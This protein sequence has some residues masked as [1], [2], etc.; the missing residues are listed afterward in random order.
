MAQDSHTI[1]PIALQVQGASRDMSQAP[2]PQGVS[3]ASEA[4]GQAHGSSESLW[5]K[6]FGT[7]ES[8]VLVV[9][10]VLCIG[11]W[12]VADVRQTFYSQRNWLNLSRQVALLS[13]FAIGETIVILTGGIDLSLGSLI[14]FSGMFLAFSVTRL[15]SR[16]Y[17]SMAVALG[18][19]VALAA[20]FS[21]GALHANLIHK[22]RLP[23]FV[24]TLASLSILRSQ[25]LLMNSQLP[26]TLNDYP[27]L[28][29]LANGSAFEKS[30]FQIP[31]PVVLLVLVAIVTHML[32]SR[33]RIGR[34]V[35]SVGSNEIGTKLSGVNV[36]R[37][38]LFAYG[39]S[40]LLGGVAGILYAGYSTQG[41][42]QNGV[43]YELNAVAAA[44]IGGTALTGGQGTVLG[45]VL[46]AVLLN[47]ILT[48]LNILNVPNQSL[49]QGTV[50]GGVLLLAVLTTAF[51][52]RKLQN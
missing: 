45:T 36:G 20:S 2:P 26:I 3:T 17:P 19:I 48:G 10:I 40:G 34:Y 4:A 51:R 29:W 1:S 24:V 33:A 15:D 11:L 38:K 16:L 49:W 32:L 23:P 35:Y 21:I 42:P 6:F 8:S 27:F 7:R 31:I 46:G 5:K 9:I 30:P 13:I 37:V 43:G 18:I 22:L 44:V 14:G 50:V 41:D 52:R 47:I 28:L 39:I 25:S 12:L